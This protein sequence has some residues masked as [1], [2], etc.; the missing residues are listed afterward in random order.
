MSDTLMKVWITHWPVWKRGEILYAPNP[1][2]FPFLGGCAQSSTILQANLGKRSQTT[3][4]LV[5]PDY[6]AAEAAAATPDGPHC[7]SCK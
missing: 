5:V 4:V 6:E 7:S 2:I 1:Y 3:L